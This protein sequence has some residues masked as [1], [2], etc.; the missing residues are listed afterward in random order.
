M[1]FVTEANLWEDTQEFE[2]ELEG[3]KLVLPK[4]MSTM[5]HAHI[6]LVVRENLEIQILEQYMTGGDCH[7]LGTSGEN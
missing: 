7:D 3:H 4:T 2:R 6:V 1:L 5:Q